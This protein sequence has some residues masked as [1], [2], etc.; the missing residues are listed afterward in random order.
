ML[1]SKHGV[2]LNVWTQLVRVLEAKGTIQHK[3]HRHPN[4]SSPA[5]VTVVHPPPMYHH[6]LLINIHAVEVSPVSLAKL[7]VL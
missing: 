1:C 7:F 4:P 2:S 3:S 6:H 5:I